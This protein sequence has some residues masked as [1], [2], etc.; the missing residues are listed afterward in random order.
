MP[1]Q[2]LEEC[3]WLMTPTACRGK[4]TTLRCSEVSMLT[5]TRFDMFVT[6]TLE[7]EH[8]ELELLNTIIPQVRS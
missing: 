2:T 1:V 7:A 6:G 5:E 4:D 8:S 3:D